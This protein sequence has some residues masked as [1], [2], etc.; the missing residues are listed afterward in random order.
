MWKKRRHLA[1]FLLFLAGIIN[2]MDRSALSI[3][4]PAVSG[5][6]GLSPSEM[7]LVFSSFFFGYAI[8]NFIGGLISD[9]AGPY[10]VF[11]LSMAVWSVFCGLTGLAACGTPSQPIYTPGVAAI[12]DPYCREA[13]A[14]ATGAAYTASVTGLP[15]D[16]RRAMRAQDFASRGC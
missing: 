10:R 3:A 5:D 9:K 2:Y 14:N 6:L 13:A 11:S 15:A 8:F 1:V 7:G 4:A 16:Q 12:P